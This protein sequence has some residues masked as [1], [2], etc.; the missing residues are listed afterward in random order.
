[1]TWV[2]PDCGRDD[3][4]SPDHVCT[5]R[6]PQPGDVIYFT[7]TAI[8]SCFWV[9]GVLHHQPNCKHQETQ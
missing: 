6:E 1:M 9:D 7:G 5:E 8:Y 2:C 3:L 4:I